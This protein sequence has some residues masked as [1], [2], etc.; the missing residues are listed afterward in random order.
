MDTVWPWLRVLARATPLDKYTLVNG[1]MES[2]MN[3]E[4]EIVAVT[5]DGTNDR[6]ALKKAH[7]GFAM[8]IH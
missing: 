7:I 3:K 1:M 5:R 2:R 6:P 4:R 8:V